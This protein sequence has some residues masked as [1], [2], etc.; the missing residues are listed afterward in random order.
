MVNMNKSKYEIV[1]IWYATASQSGESQE[2]DK[3]IE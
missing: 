2:C 3:E 1:I